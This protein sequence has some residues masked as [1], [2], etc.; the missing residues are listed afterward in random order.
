VSAP[1]A[2]R[3]PAP[4]RQAGRRTLEIF[5]GLVIPFL[6]IV[7]TVPLFARVRFAIA[8]LPAPALWLF[9]CMPLVSAC[10]A[11]ASFLRNRN[12]A[13]GPPA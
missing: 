1:E 4:R 6:L 7:P 5:V 12:A 11:V 8:G 9:L 10:L 2:P 13:A 3:G